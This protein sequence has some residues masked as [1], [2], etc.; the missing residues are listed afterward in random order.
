LRE[1]PYLHADKNGTVDGRW[2]F[3]FPDDYPSTQLLASAIDNLS[4]FKIIPY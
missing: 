4:A 2:D 3:Q 1:V